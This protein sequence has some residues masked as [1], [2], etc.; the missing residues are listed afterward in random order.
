MMSKEAYISAQGRQLLW[1][2]VYFLFFVKTKTR[3]I[4][5]A[6][7]LINVVVVVVVVVVYYT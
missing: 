3:N 2:N 6:Y 5:N 1:N 4:C 7:R